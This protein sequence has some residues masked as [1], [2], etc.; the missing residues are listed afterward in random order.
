VT[1]VQVRLSFGMLLAGI[2]ILSC[3]SGQSSE[4]PTESVST[5]TTT[6]T[7]FVLDMSKRYDV[8]CS[9]EGKAPQVYTNVKILGFLGKPGKGEKGR[10]IVSRAGGYFEHWMVLELGDG[11]RAYIR[12]RA[13]DIIEESGK[14]K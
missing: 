13:I 11:R 12:P 10:D 3:G 2:L 8:T 5:K 6:E 9:V 14:G 4:Q 7:P 1:R